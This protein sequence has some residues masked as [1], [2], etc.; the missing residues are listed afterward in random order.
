MDILFLHQSMPGQFG[1]LAAHLARD[2]EHRV[3]FLTK[4]AG[5]APARV[6]RVRYRLARQGN[7]L[8]HHYL[9]SLESAVLHGQ[10]VARALLQLRR[11]GFVPELVIAHPGWGEPMFVKDAVPEAKLINYCEFFYR[12]VGADVGFDPA[13][14]VDPDSSAR[15]RVRNAALM[16]A[17]EACDQGL[18]PMEW[19]RRVHPS[20]F[21]S[22]IEVVF[23]GV[24]TDRARPDPAACFRLPDGRL[25][26]RGDQVVTYVARNLE[27]YRGFPSFM[28]A[29]PRITEAL[30]AAQVVIAGGDDVSYGRRPPGGE[31]WREVMLREVDLDPGRVHFVGTLAYDAY[32]RLLQVSAAHVYLSYPFVLSWSAMEA[33]ATS[34]LVIGSRTPPVE[35]VI[36]DGENG[37]LVDFFSPAAIAE[38][39]IDA[40]RHGDAFAGLRQRARE[41]VLGR[42][43]LAT[44]LPRQLALLERVT[45]RAGLVRGRPIGKAA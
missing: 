13:E 35:E 29:L 15:L 43:D 36:R 28:H 32:L 18:A 45:G 16:I 26:R 34:C 17:L 7:P 33:L 23:D 39:V 4:S 44:C 22:K 1:H 10:A 40:V 42:Y 11:R 27:P 41:G 3:I 31:S 8:T 6:T 24:D 12:A 37:I 14:P 21:H 38:A 20:E 30:P 25:L 2:Q 5:S 9:H 19:Q